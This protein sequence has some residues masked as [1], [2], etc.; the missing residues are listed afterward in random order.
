MFTAF[1]AANITAFA[2]EGSPKTAAFL[3]QYCL[4]CHDKDQAKGDVVL[5]TFHQKQDLR[6]LFKVYDQTVLE[7]MPPKGKK[8][9]SLGERKEFSDLLEDV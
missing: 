1:V 3:E 5:E 2:Q 8:Q 7:Y 6:L 4:K 9:P